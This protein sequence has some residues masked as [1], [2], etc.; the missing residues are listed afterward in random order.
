MKMEQRL[1]EIIS[2]KYGNYMI[3]FLWMHGETKDELICELDAIYNCGIR[4]VC[5]ESR[6]HEEFGSNGWWRDLDIIIH[7]AKKR[8]M[9]VWILDD[10]HFPT[11]YANGLISKKYPEHRKWHLIESHVD[12]IG[13]A[14][15]SLLIE[16]KGADF[17]EKERSLFAVIA[18]KREQHEEI[19]SGQMIDL[20]D[21]VK[22]NFL[23]WNVPEGC[24]RIFM[25][26]KTRE[27]S[28]LQ[29]YIHMI[30]A[31]SVDVL[32]EA[33]Y[34]PHY[35]RYKEEFGKTFA[36][37]FSDEPCFGNGIVNSF[38]VSLP[39]TEKLPGLP[40]QALPWR[41]DIIDM[42]ISRLGNDA[43][44]L[45]PALWYDIGE[46]TAAVRY[47]Y[48]DIITALYRDCFNRRLGNWCRER[49]VQYIGHVI[50]EHCLSQG[51]GHYFRSVDGQ[52][53]S[54]IDLV[55][56]QII[57]GL[58]R[59]KHTASGS[60]HL[61]D[62]EFYHYVL[63]KLGSSQS[64]IQPL[65]KGRAM[66]E[67][68]GAY[69]W[70][71]GVP[72]MKWLLDHMLVRGINHFVPHAFTPKFPDDDCPPHFYANGNN[73]Q[74]RDFAYLMKYGNKMCHLL[75]GGIHIASAALLYHMDS[76]WCD[77]SAMNVSAP[78]KALYDNQI[79]YDIIPC[80]VLL[81]SA[82]CEN[83]RL[84]IN[85]E[86]Y[87]CLVIP[88]LLIL[89]EK[90]LEKIE[91]FSNKGLLVFIVDACPDTVEGKKFFIKSAEICN[92]FNLPNKIRE[93]T[94]AEISLDKPF[95]SLRFYHYVRDEAHYVMC[96]N[97]ALESFDGKVFL[98]F[99]GEGVRLD[100]LNG[101][102]ECVEFR[103]N[104][105]KLCLQPY[106]SCVFVYGAGYSVKSDRNCK[107]CDEHELTKFDISICSAEEYPRF[108]RLDIKT[109]TDITAHKLYP[110][111]SGYIR[112]EAK[113][114][115]FGKKKYILDLGEVG[116]TAHIWANGEYIGSRICKPYIIDITHAVISGENKLCIEVA[117]SMAYKMKDSFS[118][119]MLISPSGILGPV[120]V[121]EYEH[122]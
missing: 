83:G 20:T 8:G 98:P 18:C 104:G 87:P 4:S 31:D 36:G 53:M 41:D 97:E 59:F 86:Q 3:P 114:S 52:D 84:I 113:F 67:N 116:E 74:Y 48:M 70:A 27:G 91:E 43:K 56:H 90:V 57:P 1:S 16:H 66:C 5:L 85:K 33:V 99:D 68:F 23:Y 115:S 95:P 39:L 30:D 107:K 65:T 21:R 13:P 26:Y 46:K 101:V 108:K 69:G 51:A 94:L 88:K 49:G 79:D 28:I 117:N 34:E 73:P 121:T 118:T 80:D 42:L 22:G 35:Q 19:M 92:L 9:T 112:Y 15:G 54:G 7:E 122:K 10:K 55:L 89:P 17:N 81:N 119:Q 25:I 105:T 44:T 63:A 71:E 47:A 6:T 72:V 82:M 110:D 40:Y 111:F 78:A 102:E 50:E 106:E 29:N 120:K 96:F 11:G 45:L 75:N 109:L 37:F 100:L 58:N 93:C 61:K 64:H 2:G 62:P 77:D 76:A 103:K 12:V 32:I 14:K 60:G 24:Y 38:N